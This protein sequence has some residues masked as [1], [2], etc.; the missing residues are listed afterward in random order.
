MRYDYGYLMGDVPLIDVSPWVVTEWFLL[1][2]R[3]TDRLFAVP[4]PPFSDG[5]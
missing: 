1:W 5:S 4:T 2:R 3:C